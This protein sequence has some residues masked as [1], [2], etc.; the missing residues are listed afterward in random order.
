MLNG[1][2]LKKL[3]DEVLDGETV[4]LE[5]ENIYNNLCDMLQ[6]DKV[7]FVSGEPDQE[8]EKYYIELNY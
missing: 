3:Y 5:D 2:L 8:G 7:D 1:D 6:K 4:L